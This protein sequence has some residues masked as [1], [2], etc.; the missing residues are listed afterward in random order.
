M[1]WRW[2][3]TPPEFLMAAA[4]FCERDGTLESVDMRPRSGTECVI[5][6]YRKVAA[7]VTQP[8]A[9]ETCVD[10]KLTPFV[11]TW[12]TDLANPPGVFAGRVDSR[13]TLVKLERCQRPA[14]SSPRSRS[15]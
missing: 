11:S 10:C 14:V 2:V 15:R 1:I 12:V 7:A 8:T 4:R 3:I 6:R 5:G 9:A 13:T